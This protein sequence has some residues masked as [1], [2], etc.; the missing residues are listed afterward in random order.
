MFFLYR[1]NPCTLA[2]EA[3]LCMTDYVGIINHTSHPHVLPDKT[4]YNLGTSSTRTGPAYN[5]ICFP[6][7]KSMFEDA[8]IVGSIPCRWKL[9]P[10]YMHTFG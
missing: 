9:N 7:G 6:P 2:T 8:Y 3:R 10:G 4:V 1:I 5:V